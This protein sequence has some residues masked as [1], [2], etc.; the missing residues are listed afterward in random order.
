MIN[1]HS[2]LTWRLHYN[3]KPSPLAVTAYRSAWWSTAVKGHCPFRVELSEQWI[4]RLLPAPISS[5]K[6]VVATDLV[7]MVVGSRQRSAAQWLWS[8]RSPFYWWHL[9][10]ANLSRPPVQPS[11]HPSSSSSSS[12]FIHLSVCSA[13]AKGDEERQAY[14]LIRVSSSVPLINRDR[15]SSV[16]KTN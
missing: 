4:A 2:G 16:N 5:T 6:S 11:I 12:S 1:C 7:S 9:I 10:S 8:A 13:L 15:D 3:K 14:W